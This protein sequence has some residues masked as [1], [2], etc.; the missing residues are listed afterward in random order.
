M[1][2]PLAVGVTRKLQSF[3]SRLVALVVAGTAATL[4]LAIIT[5]TLIIY[6]AP[7]GMVTALF[8]CLFNVDKLRQP[9]PRLL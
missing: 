6:G 7:A 4:F 5:N 3:W 9:N 1:G 8:C 2:L